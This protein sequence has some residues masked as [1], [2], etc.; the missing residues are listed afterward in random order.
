M[1]H[2]HRRVKLIVIS[3][4]ISFGWVKYHIGSCPE[5]PVVVDGSLSMMVAQII[6]KKTRLWASSVGRFSVHSKQMSQKSKWK[7]LN[8]PEDVS[9]SYHHSHTHSS[10]HIIIM[11]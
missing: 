10:P 4:S 5:A 6:S 8:Q 9:I 1:R 7:E 2:C 3:V 11:S